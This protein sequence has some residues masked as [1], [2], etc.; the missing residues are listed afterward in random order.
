MN[1]VAKLQR[2]KISCRDL[3]EQSSKSPSNACR[4]L[5][6]EVAKF[7]RKNFHHHNLD[8]YIHKSEK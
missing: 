3:N 2:E 6:K 4:H 8:D 7:Q 1:E 5:T